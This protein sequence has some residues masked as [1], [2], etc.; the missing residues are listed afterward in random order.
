MLWAWIKSFDLRAMWIA[1]LSCWN[2]Q[3]SPHKRDP[4]VKSDDLSNMYL[5]AFWNNCTTCSSVPL[6]ENAHHTIIENYPPLLSIP[7]VMSLGKFQFRSVVTLKKTG[8]QKSAK[9]F[10]V[11]LKCRL[12][13]LSFIGHP[14]KL[15]SRSISNFSPNSSTQH[16]SEILLGWPVWFFRSICLSFFRNRN[17]CLTTTNLPY[18]MTR[19]DKFCLWSSNTITVKV[20]P[21][22]IFKIEEQ[23]GSE[24][25]VF[26]YSTNAGFVF[27]LSRT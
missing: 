24:C 19:W 5:A 16:N 14:F 13:I 11:T 21:L 2:I 22:P 15:V 18:A 6:Y 12:I 17:Y 25:Q 9:S 23:T 7:C 8:S 10:E 26:P 20:V 4:S 1:A 3:F 27:G